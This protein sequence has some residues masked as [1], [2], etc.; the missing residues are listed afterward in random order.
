MVTFGAVT[1]GN[2]SEGASPKSWWW[3]VSAL[4]NTDG[5]SILRCWPAFLFSWLSSSCKN[6]AKYSRQKILFAVYQHYLGA[7]QLE[8]KEFHQSTFKLL[9]PSNTNST[10]NQDWHQSFLFVCFS[11]TQGFFL[12]ITHSKLKL[13][14]RRALQ[15]PSWSL[16]LSTPCQVMPITSN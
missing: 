3:D 13:A 16:P 12:I 5:S 15:H 8:V 11:E 1:A 9:C 6:M 7:T 4:R 10:Q 14:S 2:D